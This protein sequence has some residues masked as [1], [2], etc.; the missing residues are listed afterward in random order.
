M[1]AQER[2]FSVVGR[3]VPRVEAVA[4]ATGTARYIADLE[5]PGALQI[6]LLRSHD[7]HGRIVR[8]D[9]DQAL[10][11]PG[12]KGVLTGADFTELIGE[13]ILDQPPLAR[14]K[15]RHAGEP[16]AAVIAESR[17]VGRLAVERI[18]LEL[19]PLPVLLDP[20]EA[21]APG[22]PLVHED[23][24]SYERLPIYHPV[25]G[26]NI[27]HHDRLRRGDVR[28]ALAQ[29]DVVLEGEYHF[30]LMAH[31]MLEPHGCVARWSREGQLTV[32]SCTQAPHIV[33]SLL[34][35]LLGLRENRVRVIVPWIGGG[36]GGK[37]DY[38]I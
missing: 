11:V 38:T 12:V 28:A 26:T 31:A 33:K 9:V 29:A 22:A 7:G 15:V 16:V 24:D 1:T 18:E 35:H 17:D 5:F 8:L 20:R 36:F 23:A 2:E 3:S 14:G 21:A 34:A 4:K 32:W 13:C 30:P 10:A 6:T 37:S 27:Y 19:E 25:P